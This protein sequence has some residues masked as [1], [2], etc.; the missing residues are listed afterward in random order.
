MTIWNQC[1]IQTECRAVRID[2]LQLQN[3]TLTL[4]CHENTEVKRC[5]LSAT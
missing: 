2:T 1:I 5:Y 4:Q 3:V